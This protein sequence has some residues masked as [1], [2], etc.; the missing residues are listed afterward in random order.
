MAEQNA[1]TEQES[2]YVDMQR[3]F[4]EELS[5]ARACAAK[6]SVSLSETTYRK[7]LSDVLKAK[8]TA[9]KEPRDY[10][11]LNR[12]D[13]MVIGNKSKLIYPVREGVNAIRFY[14]PDSELFD[15]LH[16]AHLAV[17]HGGRDRMLK[18]LSPK[19]K[20]IT[21]YDIELYLQICEPCQKKQKGAKKGALVLPMV[22]S[23]FNS[24]CQV[25]LIDFQSHPDGEY[26]F[27]MAYQ[28]HLTKF[29]VLVL[30]ALKSKTA[31]EVAHNLVDIFTLLGA[32]SILQSDNGRE[33]ANAVVTSLK[34]HWP[35]LKIVHGKPRHSQS[36]GSVERAN[37]DI[38]NMLCTWMQDKKTGRWS[39][40]LRFLQ[41]M[42]NRAVHSGIRRTPYEALFGC[43]AKVGLATSSLPQDVLQDVQTEEQLEEIIESV[44]TIPREETDRPLQERDSIALDETSEV[45]LHDGRNQSHGEEM[46]TEE[47]SISLICCVCLK[48]TSGA[49]TCRNCGRKVHAICGH[50]IR[51]D[52]YEKM[53]GYEANILCNLCFNIDNAGKAKVESKLNLEIQAKRMKVDSDKQFLPA[54]LGATVRV[55]VPDV[56]RGR[57]DARNLLAVGMSVTEKGFYRLGTAQGVLNQLYARSG[58]TPCRKELIRI[59][60]VP[61]QEIPLRSAAIAQSTGTRVS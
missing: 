29:V 48:E 38:E 24:R 7:L 49:Y 56:D 61:N 2:R 41:L 5:N 33:F 8:R 12:Y 6:N 39:E 17:G 31:E 45:V 18:E 25:D 20:N 27:I 15:V 14:V 10:W 52:R 44:Q 30:K 59:E 23:D 60:D 13:V 47:A 16:E 50:A 51:D 42:K 21:R 22:F 36:Q 35:S 9:K 55:P 26:K 46:V 34:Q 3:R 19:Y 57:G 58:F 43:K 53:E 28:D 1:V 54:R 40:G 4:Y 32:P 11:F 37:Q